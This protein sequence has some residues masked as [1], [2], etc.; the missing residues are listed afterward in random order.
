MMQ[1]TPP[2]GL[3]DCSGNTIAGNGTTLATLGDYEVGIRLGDIVVQIAEGWDDKI[4]N[5]RTYLACFDFVTHF[6]IPFSNL[7]DPLLSAYRLRLETGDLDYGSFDLAMY[8]QWEESFIV[9]G[10]VR[11]FCTVVDLWFG[12]GI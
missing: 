6:K 8:L 9:W 4:A 7:L 3:S 2:H 11:W 1:L 12:V 5:P 10:G